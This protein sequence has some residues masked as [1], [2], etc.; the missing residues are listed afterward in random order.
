[1]GEASPSRRT[2]GPVVLLGLATGT[3]AAVASGKTWAEVTDSQRAGMVGT[4]LL[5][6]GGQ[7]PLAS[8]LSLVVLAA[9][10]VLLVTRRRTRRV[11]AVIALLASV[12]VLATVVA[13]WWQV[14]DSL[15]KS[16]AEVG[17]TQVDVSFTGW[18]AAA[19]VA[20]VLSTLATLLALRWLGGWPEM[21][22]RYDAPGSSRG[23]SQAEPA[24]APP[25][26]RSSLDLWKAMDEGQDPTD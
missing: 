6:E 25:Q 4:G 21:G 7:M 19:A 14:P 12:G 3:L 18:Y 9:W 15:R 17:I 8:A 26:E 2:F 1:M 10:G 24:L 13:G 23:A 22:S 20:A 5:Q 16:Y 11:V